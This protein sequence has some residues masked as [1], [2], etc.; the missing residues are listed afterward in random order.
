MYRVEVDTCISFTN[1][2]SSGVG[3]VVNCEGTSRGSVE[4]TDWSPHTFGHWQLL[5]CPVPCKLWFSPRFA[6]SFVVHCVRDWSGSC[7]DVN[8]S[9]STGS[10]GLR[11]DITVLVPNRLMVVTKV[12]CHASAGCQLAPRQGV[13][14]HFD[15]SLLETSHCPTVNKHTYVYCP[16]WCLCL[17]LC[18]HHSIYGACWL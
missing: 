9:C 6:G 5:K 10:R 13:S 15:K 1:L 16:F 3:H 14:G 7:F 8:P 11:S 2:R 4:L 18:H 12:D 17:W